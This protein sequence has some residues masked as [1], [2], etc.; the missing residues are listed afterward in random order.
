MLNE[1]RIK[2]M[3]KM[4]SFEANEGKRSVSIG[5]YFRG[6]YIGKEV[7]KSVIYGTIAYVI[8]F[9]LYVA[10]DFE[11]FLQDIYKMDLLG[12]GKEVLFN[13]L[14]LIVAYSMI[15]Y[16]VY[17]LRYQKARRNLRCYYNNLRRLNSMY[18]KEELEK[19]K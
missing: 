18:R 17:A 1:S 4:A 11:F 16:V 9:A 8:V 14:K 3:T 15:T 2:L 5:T 19:N 6:D 10:Y 7:I 12:F 13:Y